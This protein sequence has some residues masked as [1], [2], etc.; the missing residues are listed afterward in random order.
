ML[1]KLTINHFPKLD[2]AAEEALNTL[3]TNLFYSGSNMRAFAI[4]SCIPDEGKTFVVMNLARTIAET[5]KKV[6]VIDADLRKSVIL[7]RYRII[8]PSGG[9]IWGLAH[10]LTGQ[11]TVEQIL[12][13]TN[14]ENLNLMPA[15][16]EIINSFALLETPYFPDLLQR[17]LD[18]YDIVL[19]DTPPV[20][21]I[22]DGAIIARYC[23]G[24]VL[25][26]KHNTVSRK[27]LAYAK[28]QI[29]QVGG[30][31]LGVVLNDVGLNA[32][33]MNK[34]YYKTYYNYSQQ[35]DMTKKRRNRKKK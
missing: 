18:Y 19:V 35:N 26:V 10:Y 22:I 27:E 33:G 11:C 24:T 4:T 5:G 25:V 32:Y 30:R 6:L 34:Y 7:G 31:V 15:G 1:D 3:W 12:Y 28:A 17:V 20:G 29:E 21:T 2:Y 8:N 23:D 9:D 14:I 13:S 16:H